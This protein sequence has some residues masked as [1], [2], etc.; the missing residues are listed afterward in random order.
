MFFK[1]G[2]CLWVRLAAGF[3]GVQIGTK[4]WGGLQESYSLS[5]LTSWY[6]SE[7]DVCEL[8]EPTAPPTPGA[9]PALPAPLSAPPADTRRT[10]AL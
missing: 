1:R 7:E 4:L 5:P 9:P 3:S 10:E 6:A 2:F 8:L